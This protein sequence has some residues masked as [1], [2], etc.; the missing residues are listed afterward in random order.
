M[1][2]KLLLA[3]GV[4][5]FSW[6]ALSGLSGRECAWPHRDLMCQGGSTHGNPTCSDE[7]RGDGRK[8]CGRG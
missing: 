7:E 8:D 1:S 2:K 6:V 3:C 5:S 4:W